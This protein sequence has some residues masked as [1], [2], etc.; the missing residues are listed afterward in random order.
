MSAFKNIN[1]FAGKSKVL[2]TFAVFC[3]IY[4]LPLMIIGLLIFGVLKRN[5][6]MFFYPLLAGLFSA[7]VVSKIV[8]IFY[9][10]KRPAKLKNTNLLIS[11]PKNPS[12]PSRHA[13][14]V[15][16]MSF[17]L[18]FYGQF[19]A[20]IFLVLSCFVGLARVFCGVH[21]LRDILGGVVAGLFSAIIIYYLLTYL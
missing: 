14:L 10:E 8:Y 20:I 21:W 18:F 12:F 1:G 3:A 19:L 13:S 4:L 6:E 2:D 17:A 11:I 16:G 15:F 5:L 9:K 7:F